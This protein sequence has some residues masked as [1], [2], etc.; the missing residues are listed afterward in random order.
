MPTANYIPRN[1]NIDTLLEA[2]TG[3]HCAA[4]I[5]LSN[6]GK[7]TLLRAM[8]DQQIAD[9]FH[10][11]TNRNATFVYIDCNRMLHLSAQGLY[12]LIIRAILDKVPDFDP[13]LRSQI[14]AS[15]TTSPTLPPTSTSPSTSTTPSP[16]LC[17]KTN[18]T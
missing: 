3:S 13:D 14:E 4:I 6:M 7:S 10:Q 12:E 16:P 5:G 15:I 2:I 17:N 18:A 1:S 8:S 9:R 11:Q